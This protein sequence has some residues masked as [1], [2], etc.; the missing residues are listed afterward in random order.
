MIQ[1][2]LNDD[3]FNVLPTIDAKSA[4]LIFTSVPDLNDLGMDDNMNGYKKFLM[5]AF[6]EF[7]RIIQDDGFVALCQTDRKMGGQVFSKHSFIITVM[8][9]MGFILKDYKIIVK[10]STDSKDLYVFPYQHLCVFTRT[11]KITKRKGDW[12]KH[13]L[14]YE[15]KKSKLGPFYGWHPEFTKLVVG[16]LTEE[17]DLVIDP[18]SGSGVVPMTAHQLNRQHIGVELDTVTYNNSV[19]SSGLPI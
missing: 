9:D 17:N 19:Y 16:T 5:D 11:G 2:F 3:C 10:N 14:I 12:L 4:K 1:K 18:F 13:I 8:C 15:V 6:I 7:D